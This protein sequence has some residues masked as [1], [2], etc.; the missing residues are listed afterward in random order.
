MREY[1]KKKKSI[2]SGF[3]RLGLEP[4]IHHACGKHANHYTT[5]EVIC[6]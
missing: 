2:N 3:T 4:M 1:R 5:D 6:N